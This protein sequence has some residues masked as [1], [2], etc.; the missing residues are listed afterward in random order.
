MA[1]FVEAEWG[2][3]AY[4][5]MKRVKDL[6]DP[7]GI[8]NPGV[9]IN[10]DARAHLR[11]LKPMPSVEEEV[12][13]CIECGFCEPRCPSRDLTTTPRQRI[14]VRREIERLR[15]EGDASGQLAALESAFPY[16]AL[17]T[18]ATDGLCATACPVSIDTGR[19]TKR[20]RAS[21]QSPSARRMALLAARRFASVERLVRL[22]LSLGPL[23]RVLPR[24]IEPMPAAARALPRTPREGAA[25]VYFASC[26]S[27]TLGALPDEPPGLS[28][29]EA[30]VEVAARAGTP[31]FLPP[32]LPGH[33]CGMPY[34]SKGFDEAHAFAVNDTIARLWEWSGQGMLPVVVDT[35]PCTLS[36]RSAS[37]LTPANR[38]RLSRMRI[39]DGVEFFANAALPRL[40]IRR[41]TGRVALHPVCS[42]TKMNLAGKLEAIGRACAESAA[43]PA[44]AGCCGFAG[45]RG[46][47]VPELTAS[48]TQDESRDIR[49]FGA[50]EIYS[51]SRTCEIGLAR[52]T[53]LPARSF[54]HLLE[55]A[56]RP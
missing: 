31:L 16:D 5:L 47:L 54:V 38:D 45:D 4:A 44:E 40:A 3:E 41:K 34:S 56:T 50:A 6:A 19:L 30:F 2:P 55:R 43:T 48:A 10:P 46:W 49:S 17:D 1:P 28:V 13:K 12:D 24:W 21:R 53:G 29:P 14:V 33:C 8:L 23:G 25:A 35:S 39:S 11:N 22:T 9:I 51:S 27:R 32:D 15:L 18:C 37:D 7:E 26:L 52:A 36:L 20:L 42:L